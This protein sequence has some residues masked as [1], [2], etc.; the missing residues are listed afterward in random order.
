MMSMIVRQLRK[1]ILLNKKATMSKI[2]P[3]IN[4]KV[5]LMN[6]MVVPLY[7]TSMMFPVVKM[8]K[9]VEI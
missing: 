1:M 8:M 2:I 9:E 3:L 4:K 7:L 5:P 6:M